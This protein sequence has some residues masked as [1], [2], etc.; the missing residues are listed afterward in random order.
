MK[1]RGVELS[2]DYAY[3]KSAELLSREIGD[4]VSKSAL[5]RS[6]GSRGGGE[7]LCEGKFGMGGGDKERG[8]SREF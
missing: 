8:S 4:W 5:L 1:R 6:L 7:I 3:R 2:C